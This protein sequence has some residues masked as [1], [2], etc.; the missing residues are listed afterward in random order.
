ML[1]SKMELN[2]TTTPNAQV[3]SLTRAPP[4]WSSYL[5]AARRYAPYCPNWT[6]PKHRYFSSLSVP[7]SRISHDTLKQTRTQLYDMGLSTPEQRELAH[8]F[9]ARMSGRLPDLNFPTKEEFSSSI[10]TNRSPP[11][12]SEYSRPL[13]LSQEGE[14]KYLCENCDRR[15]ADP[16]NL[17]RHIRQQHVGARAHPCPECG[18]T[19]ATSSGLK[20]HQHIHSSVKPFTCE[21]CHKSYTQF[22]NL[23]RHK[24]M[25][26]NCRSHMRCGTCKSLFPNISSLTKHRR[27]CTG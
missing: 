24:R 1:M 22:S 15:F 23:C 26:A 21:V 2:G 3:M 8:Q 19:F 9:A 16:S 14:K 7:G 10:N 11:T 20:Q 17:Q 13:V 27:F 25:Q 18:K 6:P 5:R 12:K 4:A